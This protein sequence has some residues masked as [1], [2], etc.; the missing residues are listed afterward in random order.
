M[1]FR[2]N[3]DVCILFFESHDL[4]IFSFG[5]IQ[6]ISDQRESDQSS[7]INPFEMQ[8]ISCLRRVFMANN[9]LQDVNSNSTGGMISGS[10]ESLPP[11]SLIGAKIQC[12]TAVCISINI[13]LELL[14]SGM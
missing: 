1:V 5:W 11:A 13:A 14:L 4:I 3:Q 6:Q 2:L 12:P 10:M 8:I 9:L 7:L